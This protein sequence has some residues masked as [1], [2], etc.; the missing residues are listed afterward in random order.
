MAGVSKYQAGRGRV[1]MMNIWCTQAKNV[2]I[3]AL[4]AKKTCEFMTDDLTTSPLPSSMSEDF[5]VRA[6]ICSKRS[7]FYVGSP[8]HR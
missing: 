7:R 2:G 3:S 8:N 4:L 6:I 1:G 5:K